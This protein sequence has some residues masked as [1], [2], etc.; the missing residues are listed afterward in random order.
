M[1]SP[2]RPGRDEMVLPKSTSS[3][4]TSTTLDYLLR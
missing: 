2:L 3:V 1:L 4:F